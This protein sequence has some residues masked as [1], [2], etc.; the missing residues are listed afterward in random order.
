MAGKK[1]SKAQDMRAILTFILIAAIV[2]GGV[3][4]Y[5]GLEKVRSYA[6][7]VNNHLEDAEASDQ[8][9]EQL[10]LLKNQL[11]QSKKLISTADKLFVTES[12]YQAKALTDVRN[13]ADKVGLSVESTDFDDAEGNHTIIVRLTQPTSY[14]KLVQFLTLVEGNLPKMQVDSMTLTRIA[15]NNVDTVESGDIKIKVSVRG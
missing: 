13:Y 5:F 6:I 9:V 10:Q 2:G 3:L 15:D 4:F 14:Q 7:E 12:A 11:S 1:T 8:Q